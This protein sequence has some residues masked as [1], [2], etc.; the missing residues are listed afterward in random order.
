MAPRAPHNSCPGD[1]QESS[2]RASGSQNIYVEPMSL[3]PLVMRPLW[4]GMG[5]ARGAP[6]GSLVAFVG[7]SR[8]RR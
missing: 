6:R 7:P 3:F 5:W 1:P 8:C 2:E 4:V